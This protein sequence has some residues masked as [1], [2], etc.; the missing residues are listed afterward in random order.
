MP[1]AL[2]NKAN[3]RPDP[4]SQKDRPALSQEERRKNLKERKEQHESTTYAT[5][6]EKEAAER[7]LAEEGAALAMEGVENGSSANEGQDPTGDPVVKTENDEQPLGSIPAAG[8]NVGPQVPKLQS[9][10]TDQ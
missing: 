8:T 10:Q 4:L 6:E 1:P 9:I 2:T 5:P 7:A 3:N